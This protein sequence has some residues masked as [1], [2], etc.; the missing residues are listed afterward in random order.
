MG[1]PSQQHPFRGIPPKEFEKNLKIIHEVIQ[2]VEIQQN[3]GVLFFQQMDI[4][5]DF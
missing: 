5:D 2:I 3:E 4:F 1:I